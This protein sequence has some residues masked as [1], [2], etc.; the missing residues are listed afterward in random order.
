MNVGDS[1]A[2]YEIVARLKAGG[3]A[4]LYLGRR[5]RAG[6]F[7]K[8]VAIKI[9]H[10][11]LAENE[12]FISM[13]L[14]EARITA[15]IEHPNVVHVHDL[16]EADGKYFLVM[17]YV[18]GC[19]LSQLMRAI[20]KQR[21]RLSPV[22]A[23]WIAMQTAAG[24]H[25]AHETTDDE[26][27]PLGLVHRDVSPKNILLAY[28]GYVKLIDFGIAKAA[29]RATHT[30]A[31]L[32]KG[33]FRYMSPEQARG[34]A[35]DAR[36]DVFALGV[37]LWEMLTS[38]RLFDAENDLALLDQV[39][40]PQIVPPG[41]LVGGIPPA[42]DAVVMRAL[43]KDPAARPE[44]ADAFRMELAQAV[45]GAL[46][47]TARQIGELVSLTM[48]EPSSDPSMASSVVSALGKPLRVPR[49]AEVL[50]KLTLGPGEAAPMEGAAALKVAPQPTLVTPTGS[51]VH[52][53]HSGVVAAGSSALDHA[54]TLVTPSHP[55][56][57]DAAVANGATP[58]P[59][60][61]PMP[62]PLGARASGDATPAPDGFDG[63]PARRGGRRWLGLALGALLLVGAG[64]AGAV[65]MGGRGASPT[66]TPLA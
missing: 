10:E 19:A 6:G 40:D 12:E 53:V 16:G 36:S 63:A 52:E 34:R 57:L 20:G 51:A 18:P 62:T 4:A 50:Q 11:H 17:E 58:A 3:M 29:G 42:L 39:R 23:T 14:D 61:T 7:A 60:F 38:R 28:K 55:A 66:S 2:E 8:T 47:T 31:G 44:T 25:A 15:R 45:P 26:G 41:Q 24:L 32:L 59:A 43:S 30:A 54:P 56:S 33:T 22:A 13:F 48:G 5:A 1:I 37:V 46:A 65:V 64:V 49:P 21:R 27:R 9:V 35:L